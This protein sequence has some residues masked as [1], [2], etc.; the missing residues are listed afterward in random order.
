MKLYFVLAYLLFSS[1]LHAQQKGVTETGEQ[2]ILYENGTWKYAND[3][4]NPKLVIKVNPVEFKKSDN[5]NFLLKSKK[6]EVG[7]WI[8]PKKWIFGK[9]ISNTSAEYE[10]S[11]KGQDLQAVI[12]IENLEVPLESLKK[13]AVEN[14]KSTSPDYHIVHEEYRTVN[15]LKILY[16]FSEGTIS[17]IKFNFSAYYYSDKDVAIQFLV[18]DNK[19]DKYKNEIEELLNGIS[20]TGPKNKMNAYNNDSLAQGSL[21]S[22]TQCKKFF[23]GTWQY[24]SYNKKIKVIRTLSKTTEYYDNFFYE[25][26]NRWLDNCIYEVIFK[27]TSQPNYKLQKVGELM[28]VDILSIDKTLMKY[29]VLYKGN[30]IS[31]EMVRRN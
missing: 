27:R 3:F 29:E 20:L 22:N 18:I 17:D 8:D 25:Y 4:R 16:T 2:V 24:E 26:E 31:G 10:L 13:I 1:L 15:G 30:T 5:A 28:K 21:S 9:A 14:A 19:K 23:E 11:L 12:I 7:F 6:A